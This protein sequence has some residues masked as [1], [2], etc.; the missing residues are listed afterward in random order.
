MAEDPFS[1]A[2]RRVP[3]ELLDVE[4]DTRPL[5]MVLLS[6]SLRPFLLIAGLAVFFLILH[7]TPPAGLSPAGE[8]ALA[9]FALCVIYWVTG[10]LPLVITGLLAIILLGICG[11][12]PARTAY[13]LF[14]SEAV[15][16]VLAAFMLA[17]AVN[18]RGL[19]RRVA[20]IVFARFGRT[21]NGLIRAIYLLS[22]LM[23]FLIPEHA[24]AAIVFPIVLNVADSLEPAARRTRYPTALF[25]AMAWGTNIGGIAT[26][27]GGARGPLALGILTESTGVTISFIRWSAATIPLVALL[28]LVG[29]LVLTAF[30]AYEPVNID[31]SI[32][33]ITRRRLQLG[34]ISFEETAV[35]AVLAVTV[36]AWSVASQKLGL[37]GIAILAVV[38]LFVLDLLSWQEV[39]GHVNWGIILMYGGAIALGSA[40]ER[41]KAAAFIAQQIA[42]QTS[43]PTLLLAALSL[44]AQFLGETLSHSAVVASLLPVGLGLARRFG[45]DLRALTLAIT[46]PAGL[47]YIMPVSTPANALAY[48]GGYLRT[49]D[50]LVPGLILIFA[51]WIGLNL[52]MHLY[53]PL[54][55]FGPLAVKG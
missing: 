33:A 34:R 45:L 4:V 6:R 30:F 48:S 36:V 11:V 47:T 20:V 31:P 32:A 24:V 15:F 29:Y 26:L 39:E 3:P 51:S 5:A 54:L 17:A 41:S 12:M 7:A 14:G 28:L 42:K 38:A 21:S 44:T 27:L 35:A 53:W 16:F 55:G 52:V 25:L 2:E 50:L 9:I 37:A 8:R 49:K 43:S 22:A 18:Y 13:S 46:L 23:S 1:E 10:A 19:G 40:L